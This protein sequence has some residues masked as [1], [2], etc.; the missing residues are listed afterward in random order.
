MSFRIKDFQHFFPSFIFLLI[1]FLIIVI[2]VGITKNANFN[3]M[4]GP[5]YPFEYA[6]SMQDT[7]TLLANHCKFPFIFFANYDVEDGVYEIDP[8]DDCVPHELNE[9]VHL[10]TKGVLTFR[11]KVETNSTLKSIRCTYYKHSGVSERY[12]EILPDVPV[13]IPHYN[14]AFSCKKDG[15]VEFVKPFVNFAAIPK[16]VPGESVAVIFLPSI[17][18]LLFTKKMTRTK[19]LM[20]Q[21]EFVFAQMMNMKQ[22]KPF[23]DL[24]LQL[25]ISSD[26]SVF[27]KATKQN[28]TTFF[29]GPQQIRDLIDVDYDTTDHRK[30][31]SDYLIDENLC[32]EDGRK[33]MDDQLENIESF[34]ESTSGFKFFS[35]L[36]LDDYGSQ[37]SLIDYDLSEMISRLSQKGIFKSTTLIVTSY[38]SSVKEPMDLNS[39]NPL[40]AI[41]VSDNLRPSLPA[42]Q[43]Y[44]HLNSYRLLTTANSYNLIMNMLEPK[45]TLDLS[46]LTLQSTTGSCQT[47]GISEKMCLCM[48]SIATPTFPESIRDGYL[49]KLQ[50]EFG[51]EIQKY[52]CV[53]SHEI[54]NVTEFFEYDDDR[55]K[56]IVLELTGQASIIG[57]NQTQFD[58]PLK[59]TFVYDSVLKYFREFDY[60]RMLI[61]PYGVTN[62]IPSICLL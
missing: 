59:K 2:T 61:G 12:F 45:T 52:K 37:R 46:P 13:Q 16:E 7:R 34:L 25:G 53:K 1:A 27:Q 8:E 22:E 38:D 21:N 51:E 24:L 33:L 4:V 30:L 11:S 29:S 28:F 47:A 19:N 54:Q 9:Y 56:L 43:Y 57:M 23:L 32:L 35:A 20:K 58:V 31:I 36:F 42:E 39:K 40:F 17:H 6:Y 3:P 49:E 60:A 5:S 10:S 14:F 44:F 62:I 50:K 18:H 26:M 55:G 48:K 41:R 15:I